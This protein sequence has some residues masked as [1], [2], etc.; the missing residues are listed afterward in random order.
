MSA[1]VPGRSVVVM[2]T[3]VAR[4]WCRSQPRYARPAYSALLGGHVA[5][6]TSVLRRLENPCPRL[7]SG[8]TTARY[9]G[10]DAPGDQRRGERRAVPPGHPAED[11]LRRPLG[12][13]LVGVYANGVRVDQAFAKGVHVHPVAIIA[14]V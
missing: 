4:Q 13:L 10:R 6:D 14:E 1:G 7:L 11:L 9:L 5:A 8:T 3:I 2:A 12:R